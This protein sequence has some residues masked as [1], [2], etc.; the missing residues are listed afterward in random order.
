M[1]EHG[2]ARGETRGLRP[3]ATGL[4]G[5]VTLFLLIAVT[6]ARDTVDIG[7][8]LKIPASLSLNTLGMGRPLTAGLGGFQPVCYHAGK[9]ADRT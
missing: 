9:P 7:K 3:A 8:T 4:A 5:I 6:R 1:C 2:S